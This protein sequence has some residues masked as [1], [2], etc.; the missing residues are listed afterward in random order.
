MPQKFGLYQDLL[1]QKNLSLYAD[2][3]GVPEAERQKHYVRLL[4]ITNL[5]LLYPQKN[6]D[7]LRLAIRVDISWPG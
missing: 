2:L 7:H 1:V 6:H 5:G 4:T 3:Q